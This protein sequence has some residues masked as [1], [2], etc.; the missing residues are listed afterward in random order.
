MAAT[1]TNVGNQLGS[2]PHTKSIIREN[3]VMWDVTRDIHLGSSSRSVP[4]SIGQCVW[5]YDGKAWNVKSVD[6]PEPV[7]TLEAPTAPGRF[8][9]QLRVTPVVRQTA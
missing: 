4:E 3:D 8:K 7:G 9:G 6:A 1:L 5:E 2:N